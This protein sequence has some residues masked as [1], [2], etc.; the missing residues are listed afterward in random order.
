MSKRKFNDDYDSD[1]DYHF[2]NKAIEFENKL[3]KKIKNNESDDDTPYLPKAIEFENYIN[4][5]SIN[6]EQLIGSSIAFDTQL[7]TKH[8]EITKYV[9]KF[10]YTLKMIEYH[11]S[12]QKAN[13][14]ISSMNQ[15]KQFIENIVTQ[16][17]NTQKENT[18]I[19]I[20]INHDLFTDNINLPFQ[21]KQQIK[22][23]IIWNVLE[24]TIQSRKKTEK[25][26]IK[27]NHKIVVT[28]KIAELKQG[29]VFEKSTEDVSYSARKKRESRVLQREKKEKLNN[30]TAINQQQYIQNSKHVL[31]VINTDNNCFMRA[32]MLAIAH[33]NNDTDRFKYQSEKKEKFNQIVNSKIT[34]CGL[35]NN[36]FVSRREIR[37]I[38]IYFPDVQIMVIDENYKN[39]RNE[40]IYLN[41]NKQYKNHVYILFHNNHYDV[42]TSIKGYLKAKYYCHHCKIGCSHK[43]RH[44]CSFKCKCCYRDNEICIKENLDQCVCNEITRNDYC[45]QVHL[46]Y[47]KSKN[48][49]VCQKCSTNYDRYHVCIDQKYCNSCK[50]VVDLD[51]HKCFILKEKKK[52]KKKKDKIYSHYIFFDFETKIDNQSN[53]HVVNLAVAKKICINCMNNEDENTRCNDCK[54]YHK[55]HD[56]NSFCEWL[57]QQTNSI[58]IAHNLKGYDG[59]FIYNYF[60]KNIKIGDKLAGPTT[61]TNG[62]KLMAIMWRS[63]RIIDSLC[64]IPV[65]LSAFSKTFD[66]NEKKKGFFPHQFNTDDNQNYNGP[67]PDA[68]YYQPD[69]MT[70]SKRDEFFEWYEE[71]KHKSFDFKKEFEQYCFSDVDLLTEGCIRFRKLTMQISKSNKDVNGVDPFL[72]SFTIASYCNLV[73]RKKHMKENSIGLIPENGYHPKQNTSKKARQWLKYIAESQNIYIIHAMNSDEFKIGPYYVDGI[74]HEKKIIFEFHGCHWHGCTVCFTPDTYSNIKKNTMKEINDMHNL[75]IAY[76]QNNM[77]EG[78]Q[79]IQIWEHEWDDLCISKEEIKK[80]VQQ[81]PIQNRLNPRNCMF[82]GRTNGLNLYRKSNQNEK[83]SYID[84]TSLY[85]YVQKYK[86]FPIGHPEIITENINYTN[87]YYYGLMKCR[88]IPPKKLYIPVIPARINGKLMFPLCYKCASESNTICT[89]SEYERAIE[90]E[91]CTLEIYESIKYGYKLD[92]IYEVWHWDESTIIDKDTNTGGLFTEYINAALKIKQEASGFPDNVTSEDQKDEYI[93]QYLKKEGI[94]L[95]KDKIKKNSGLRQIAKW[96]LNSLWGRLAMNSNKKQIKTITDPNEWQQMLSNDAYIISDIHLI[97]DSEIPVLNLSYKLD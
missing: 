30:R 37:K 40:P 76:I 8:N 32:L 74:C 29:G 60:L 41:K 25:L 43:E 44:N 85:P 77:P 56:I 63:L 52:H 68:K 28:F 1:D 61:I 12:N 4:N 58:V 69:F 36:K 94:S 5:N 42:I 16:F 48:K 18:K 31:K 96:M 90:G 72:N 95:D 38:Q 53:Q 46:K 59:I 49:Q 97:E 83:I 65:A 17:V 75:R 87:N 9:K 13:D 26:E 86:R 84:Y 81:N 34:E 78:Y 22:P 14:I 20:C 39:Y 47:C 88:L 67:W 71:N 23:E 19:G 79:L 66:I 11:A 93:D 54:Q 3:S 80:F 27:D 50:K 51:S 91:W 15:T 24:N 2:I 55:F 33:I 10:D 35:Q 45:K 89:H 21:L 64:F 6:N 92:Y 82:G 57:L 62:S 70:K 7:Y 73:Y